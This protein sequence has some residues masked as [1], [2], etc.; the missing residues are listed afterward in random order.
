MTLSPQYFSAHAIWDYVNGKKR[1]EEAAAQAESAT[2]PQGQRA[3]G[4]DENSETYAQ[5]WRS[6]QGVYNATAQRAAQFE[7]RVSQLEGLIATRNLNSSKVFIERLCGILI[8][9]PN[10]LGNHLS[11]CTPCSSAESGPAGG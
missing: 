11:K 6:L 1:A 9:L 7:Q 2:P 5:R 4:E 3:G 8:P 10:V